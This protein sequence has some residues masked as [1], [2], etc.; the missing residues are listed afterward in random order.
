MRVGGRWWLVAPVGVLFAAD[1][2]LTLCGQPAEYWAGDTSAA[3]EA[4][5][6]AH[7]LLARSPWLFA[8]LATA[9]IVIVMA[10]ILKW[11]HPAS[12]WLAA[13]VALSHALGGS[14]WLARTGPWGWVAAVAYLAAAV[15]L[16][17]W[18]HRRASSRPRA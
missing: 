10:A 16:V 6:L 12:A 11:K 3:V 17:G 9:W 4:N 15:E 1:V 13:G 7:P 2:A 18:S 5:P 14:S 8:G